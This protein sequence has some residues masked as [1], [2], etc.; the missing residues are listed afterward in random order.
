MQ[1]KDFRG[2]VYTRAAAAVNFIYISI[3]IPSE[4]HRPKKIF[5]AR[6]VC[7]RNT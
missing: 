3:G 7:T 2:F 1:I 4:V 5:R 6:A